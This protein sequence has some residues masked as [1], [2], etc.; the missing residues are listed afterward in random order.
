MVQPTC[1]V[2]NGD[3]EQ[4]KSYGRS[5]VNRSLASLQTLQFHLLYMSIICSKRRRSHRLDQPILRCRRENGKQKTTVC[6]SK[7]D[8][9][10]S[11]L[12]KPCSNDLLF[13]MSYRDNIYHSNS[14]IGSA[15]DEYIEK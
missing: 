9:R 15:R 14:Y 1:P 5:E 4:E 13:V 3:H 2:G 10:K 8:D 7:L 12:R 11:A 6:E